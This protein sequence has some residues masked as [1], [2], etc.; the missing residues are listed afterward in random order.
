MAVFRLVDP[1]NLSYI[2]YMSN[3]ALPLRVPNAKDRVEGFVEQ[4]DL[5]GAVQFVL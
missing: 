2:F 3:T 1:L 4:R 5:D